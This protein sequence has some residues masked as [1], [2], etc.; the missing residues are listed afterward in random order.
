KHIGSDLVIPAAALAFTFYYFSTIIDSPWTA[1]VSAFFIGAVLIALIGA[2]VIYSLLSIRRG[3]A[4][5]GFQRLT[6]PLSF[7]PRRAA[8][9]ALTIFFIFFVE[10]GGFTITTFIFLSG[11]MLLLSRGRNWKFILALSATLAIGGYFLFVYAFEVRFPKGPFELM[12][13]QVL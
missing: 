1:Q 11:A 4:D 8:L 2:F 10:W 5:L 13:A 3:E 9:F 12:M 6:E 7:M